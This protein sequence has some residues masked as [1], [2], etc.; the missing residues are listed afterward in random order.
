[1]SFSRS[2]ARVSFSVRRNENSSNFSAFR[3][4][5]KEG[6]ENISRMRRQRLFYQ[7]VRKPFFVYIE[8]LFL[9]PH[10]DEQT[11]LFEPMGL[12]PTI[13]RTHSDTHVCRATK[14]K[15]KEKAFDIFT[16]TYALFLEREQTMNRPVAV[17]FVNMPDMGCYNRPVF[18]YDQ[19]NVFY[20]DEISALLH[21]NERLS[22]KFM[23]R[24]K[25]NVTIL[26]NV[27]AMCSSDT[28][29]NLRKG[30]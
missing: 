22:V 23:C 27:E 30:R 8:N 19:K 10:D 4:Q 15:K 11:P 14:K 18:F 13:S 26:H 21:T 12:T 9:L 5:R 3:I 29:H 1:M 17:P 2:L 25:Q 28:Y 6:G 16:G 7:N 24:W 20:H